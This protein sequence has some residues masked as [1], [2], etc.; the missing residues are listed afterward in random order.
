M[1]HD[2]SDFGDRPFA[3]L[4]F[5]AHRVRRSPRAILEDKEPGHV[6]ISPGLGGGEPL[7]RTMVSPP[8]PDLLDSLSGTKDG[9]RRRLAATL[10]VPL[11][12]TGPATEAA[13]TD[14]LGRLHGLAPWC[15]AATGYALDQGLARLDAGARWYGAEPLLIHGPPGAG[16]TAWATALA[17][18]LGMPWARID[19]GATASVFAIAGVEAGW[20]STAPGRPVETMAASGCANPIIIVDEADKMGKSA[21]SG[22]DPV[23]AL[24]ALLEPVSRQCWRC[25]HTG[26]DLDMSRLTWILIANDPDLVPPVLRDR[27]K[28][29]EVRPPRAG[30]LRDLLRRELAGRAEPEIIDRLAGDAAGLSL[31]KVRRIAE[32]LDAANRGIR[33]RAGMH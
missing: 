17:S 27:C 8:R 23:G 4:H 11:R 32:A 7:V 30:E 13:L 1:T 22:G 10:T 21:S 3:D 16:K 18:T 24:L 25:V 33:R 14:A 12:L 2:D 29:V 9:A 5:D 28:T 15:A 6:L 26:L 31:R 20:S 19:G